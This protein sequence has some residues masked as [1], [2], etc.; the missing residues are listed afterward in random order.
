[1]KIKITICAQITGLLLLMS[2][3]LS[4]QTSQGSWLIGNGASV[5]HNLDEEAGNISLGFNPVAGYFIKDGFMLGLGLSTYYSQND[6]FKS[7]GFGVQPVGRYYFV[8][9]KGPW[10]FFAAAG[11]GWEQSRFTFN[12]STTKDNRFIADAGVGGDYFIVPTIGVEGVLLYNASIFEN[13]TSHNILLNT[14]P[15]FFL[16]SGGMDTLEVL[17]PAIGRGA[18]QFD[19]NGQ[20]TLQNIGETNHFTFSIRPLVKYFFTDHI[21][22]GGALQI[23]FAEENQILYPDLYFKYY[24][25]ANSMRFQPFVEV[26]PGFRLQFADAGDNRFNVNLT[27]GAGFDYFV[28]PNVALEGKLYYNGRR[29]EDEAE[30]KANL[31]QFDLGFAFFLSELKFK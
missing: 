19:L 20:I 8:Q 3:F 11:V 23:A 25:F 10:A 2:T 30:E 17:E 9:G 18:V 13:F 28:T 21:A 12:N 16:P 27:A 15:Q 4:A 5:S 1:M 26:A 29:L 24:P 6:P 31:L 7:A 22:A 14:S